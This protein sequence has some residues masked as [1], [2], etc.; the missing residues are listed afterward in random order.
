MAPLY[1]AIKESCIHLRRNNS[2]TGQEE[3][4]VCLEKRRGEI[5]FLGSQD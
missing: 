3:T 4:I 1:L 5:I 2:V